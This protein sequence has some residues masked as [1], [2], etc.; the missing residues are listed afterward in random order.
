[1]T[2]IFSKTKS[3]VDRWYKLGVP[4]GHGWSML[5]GEGKFKTGEHSVSWPKFP[6]QSREQE[7]FLS[8]RVSALKRRQIK[9]R[10]ISNF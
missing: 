8:L 1:M 9:M 10:T 2:H 7:A 6:E 3:A 4:L 5:C